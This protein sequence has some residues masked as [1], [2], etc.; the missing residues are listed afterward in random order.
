MTSKKTPLP[1]EETL[2]DLALLRASEIDFSSLVPSGSI[3]TESD[4]NIDTSV[5]Q[6]YEFVKEARAALKVHYRDD[7]EKQGARV[8]DVRSRLDD[9]LHG[10]V[11]EK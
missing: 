2:R 10:L 5:A 3:S 6:S 1:F 8:E 7:V 11:P 9:V 4:P